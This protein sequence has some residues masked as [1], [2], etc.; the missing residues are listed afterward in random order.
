MEKPFEDFQDFDFLFPKG[1]TSVCSN[2]NI[3]LVIQCRSFFDPSTKVIPERNDHHGISK[4]NQVKPYIC[5]N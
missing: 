5:V 3:D 1:G 2:V 4:R